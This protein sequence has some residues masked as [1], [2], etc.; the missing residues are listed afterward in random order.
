MSRKGGA[1]LQG[2]IEADET[3]IGSKPRKHGKYKDT[4]PSKRGRGTKKTPIIDAVQRGGKVVAQVADNLTGRSILEFIRSAIN[5]IDSKGYLGTDVAN[6]S[7][8]VE[9][10]DYEYNFETSATA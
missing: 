6:T 4:E 3:Y 5:I 2:V 7:T 10:E 8:P 1:L 9:A